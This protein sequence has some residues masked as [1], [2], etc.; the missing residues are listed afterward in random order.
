MIGAPAAGPAGIAGPRPA[1]P[2]VAGA[3]GARDGLAGPDQARATLAQVVG[4]FTARWT[5]W[6]WPGRTGC[7]PPL[8]CSSRISRPSRATGCAPRRGGD[9]TD[10]WTRLSAMEAERLRPPLL[11]SESAEV[12]AILLSKLGVAKA[13]AL[14]ADL[15]GTGR[16]SSP[17]PSALDRDGH[18]AD[19]RPDRRAFVAA[20]AGRP[21]T[22]LSAPAPVDRIGAILNSVGRH[23]L[24][25]GAF[26]AGSRRATRALRA[27]CAA[28]SSPSRHILQTGRAD[29]CAPH[30]APGGTR[31]GH[32]RAGGGLRHRAPFGGVLAGEHVQAPG[33]TD[34]RRGRGRWAPPAPTRAR[35]RWPRW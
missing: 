13:A 30:P 33:R 35:R 10:P 26:W 23:E 8:P 20:D 4:E 27:M 12:A 2:R 6:R 5:A 31:C 19:G 11:L 18:A 34:A 16:R 28:R 15:P 29:G 17:M 24:R 14:L 21:R 9:P 3:A 25:R 7:R 1:Q 32:P 22:C